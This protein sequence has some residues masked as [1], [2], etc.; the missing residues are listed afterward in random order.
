MA[1][2]FLTWS[3]VNFIIDLT[4]TILLIDLINI[5]MHQILSYRY[6]NYGYQG[7]DLVKI[8]LAHS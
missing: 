6:G 2:N 5:K 3:L 4:Y 7:P 1:K 8:Q